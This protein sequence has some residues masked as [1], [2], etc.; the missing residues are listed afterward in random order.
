M[1]DKIKNEKMKGNQNCAARSCLFFISAQMFSWI[2]VL[3]SL[4]YVNSFWSWPSWACVDIVRSENRRRARLRKTPHF[5]RL[6]LTFSSRI[7]C[8]Q[9][10]LELR[11]FSFHIHV[12]MHLFMRVM[13]GSGLLRTL[14]SVCEREYWRKHL[15]FTN[16]NAGEKSRK[17]KFKTKTW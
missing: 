10:L 9:N 1:H 13:E 3:F 7:I 6:P 8:W 4:L 14:M 2:F 5:S 17:N 15:H 16:Y 12:V 11:C